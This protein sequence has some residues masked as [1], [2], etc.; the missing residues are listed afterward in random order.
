M[1][2]GNP[3]T[4]A[5]TSQQWRRLGWGVVFV[6]ACSGLAS[7]QAAG[8]GSIRS[9]GIV[10]RVNGAPIAESD[11]RDEIEALYPS[12]SAHGGL[13][14]EK[15]KDIRSKALEEL[16]VEELAYQRAVTTQTL[17]P[18]TEVRA[19]YTRL[20][21]KY[22]A[23]AFDQSLQRSGLTR[24]QYLKKLQRRMTLGKM[25]KQKLVLPSRVGPQA[26]R[27]Y[28]D[29]HHQRFTRP[30]A[31]HARLILAAVDPKG[32]PQAEQKAKEKIEKVCQEL[33]AGKD[34]GLLAEQYSDD[35]YAVKGGDL[36]W[37]HRGQ[38][39]PEFEKVAFGMQAGK[40]SEPFRTDYGYNLMKVE[41]HELER[42]MGFDEV[43]PILK[44]Q[45][46]K[47]KYEDLRASWIAQLKKDARIEIEEAQ[48]AATSQ[49][50]A[51][52]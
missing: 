31:V 19:E 22:G 10:A 5:D 28:Y 1:R 42:L 8:A 18:M 41:G 16:I 24:Q 33:K 11:L 4:T 23:V 37:Q 30:E 40:F 52:H 43:R 7:A 50:Q 2:K 46:E 17:R 45:L 44:A 13:R 34:F 27:A 48:P 47:D 49:P 15:L 25:A 6:M 12:N 38:L 21:S 29:T 35:Y 39:D 3:M 51:A 36:G 20:R 9:M 26:L 14:P 32:G